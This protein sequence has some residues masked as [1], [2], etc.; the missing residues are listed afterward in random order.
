MASLCIPL[1][2]DSHVIGLLDILSIVVTS[3]CFL[4]PVLFSI[5]T[6]P[7]VPFSQY[8]EAGMNKDKC[9][10][11][12]NNNYAEYNKSVEVVSGINDSTQI[13]G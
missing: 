4:H 5:Y 8:R 13:V 6:V 2:F 3:L 1:A 11:G 9:T 7:H 12:N 10:D